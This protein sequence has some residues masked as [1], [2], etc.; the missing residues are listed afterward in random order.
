MKQAQTMNNEDMEGDVQVH[1]VSNKINKK[2]L[3]AEP[4]QD[5]TSEQADGGRWEHG[6][7]WHAALQVGGET[8]VNQK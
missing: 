4:V 2:G 3:E 5:K 7:R 1:R 8:E 6:W